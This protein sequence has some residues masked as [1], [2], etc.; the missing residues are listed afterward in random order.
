MFKT[1]ARDLIV[2]TF[3]ITEERASNFLKSLKIKWTSV[4]YDQKRMLEKY[5]WWLEQSIGITVDVVDSV[6]KKTRRQTKIRF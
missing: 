4:D 1:D 6:Y 3:E 2:Q 5:G